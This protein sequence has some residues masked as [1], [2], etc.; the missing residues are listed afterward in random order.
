MLPSRVKA[1]NEFAISLFPASKQGS[2]QNG[3]SNPKTLTE[4]KI[5]RLL[6]NYLRKIFSSL[7]YFPPGAVPFTLFAVV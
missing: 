2:I 4:K 1:E 7:S 6:D 5:F 3:N